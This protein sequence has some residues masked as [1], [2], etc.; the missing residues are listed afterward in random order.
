LLLSGYLIPALETEVKVGF[1]KFPLD[2][3]LIR[4]LPVL[5]SI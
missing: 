4:C 3:Q 5:Q 2:P 1:Q